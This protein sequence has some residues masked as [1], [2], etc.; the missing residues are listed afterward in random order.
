MTHIVKRG[1][2]LSKIARAHGITLAQLLDA[3]PQFK[4]NPDIVHVGDELVI[5]AADGGEP[6]VVVPQTAPTPFAQRLAA[7]AQ[8]QHATFQFVRESDP[9]LCAAIKR[10]TEGIGA[11]FTSCTSPN[12]PWSAVFISWCVKEAGARATEFRFSKAHAVFVNKAIQ[13]AD[14]GRGV[15][16][17]VP[18]TE[19]APRVGDI[20]H[21]N[22]GGGRLTFNFARNNTQYQSHSV[23][24]A[25]VGEDP[26]GHFA[27]CIGGNE[28]DSVRRTKVRLTPQGFIRQR[29]RDPFISVIKTLK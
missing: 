12:H 13:D 5:P 7:V 27:L 14:N 16:H 29:G 23:I 18:I 11:S 9:Q 28:S 21:H 25:E 8:Q 24:V 4:P 19:H 15:F 26:D 22:R 17:G 20:I 1:E 3:N 10:W 2:T 6:V